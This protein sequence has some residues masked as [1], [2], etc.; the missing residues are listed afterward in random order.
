MASF[1]SI[2]NVQP[3]TDLSQRPLT[4]KVDRS[5]NELEAEEISVGI[6]IWVCT[7]R[8]EFPICTIPAQG[9]KVDS[10]FELVFG[11]SIPTDPEK[12]VKFK[13]SQKEIAPLRGEVDWQEAPK[14]GFTAQLEIVSVEDD[15]LLPS[16]EPIHF[17]LPSF[18][19]GQMDNGRWGSFDQYSLSVRE[20]LSFSSEGKTKNIKQNC[21]KIFATLGTV[22]KI[23]LQEIRSAKKESEGAFPGLGY[24]IGG[25]DLRGH[26]DHRSQPPMANHKTLETL[27]LHSITA[28]GLAVEKKL[29]K[30]PTQQVANVERMLDWRACVEVWQLIHSEMGLPRV[31][32]HYI[33][34]RDGNIVEL[35]QIK[36]CA[37]HAGG[38]NR[39][40]IGR[41]NA[42]TMGIELI[43]F[44]DDFRESIIK[45][46]LEKKGSDDGQDR[47][48]AFAF[49]RLVKL[50]DPNIPADSHNADDFINEDSPF[51]HFT[52][53]QY[54]ALNLL[55]RVI[56]QRFGYIRVCT[57]QWLRKRV[58]KIVTVNGVKKKRIMLEKMDPGTKF[59][60]TRLTTLIPG[61][62]AGEP[63]SFD[64]EHVYMCKGYDI[65]DRRPPG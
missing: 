42:E 34:A 9:K 50:H 21:G 16:G 17:Q 41:G 28:Q 58:E 32:A 53:A 2:V 39:N 60:R 11:P 38:A 62:W 48:W 14:F 29:Y 51:Y 36:H 47:Q 24:E 13:N 12:T 54:E 25:I 61:A 8:F 56:G 1:F 5:I 40:L 30:T 59:D 43:G 15:V 31:S 18:S 49:E 65:E 64:A 22:K 26:Y 57:H 37:H 10:R 6:E 44:A 52:D 20:A 3:T 23:A 35:V 19:F 33:I 4:L 45:T 55:I 7:P 63:G 27:V 46:Y